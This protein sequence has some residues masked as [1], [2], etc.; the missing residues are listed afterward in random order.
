MHTITV[1]FGGTSLASASQIRKAA[2]II[3]ADPA[4]RFVVASAPGKRTKDD[5]KVTDLLIALADAKIAG[6]ARE[7]PRPL[8]GYHHGAGGFL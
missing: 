3:Q 5:I 1:K 6:H 7:D 8:S 2:E 4:R